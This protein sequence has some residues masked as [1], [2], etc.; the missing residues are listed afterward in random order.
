M[1]LDIW[2]ERSG[3]SFGTFEERSKLELALPVSSSEDITFSII[4]GELPPGL[5]ISSDKIVGTPFEVARVTSFKFCIRA[6]GT[7]GIADRTFTIIIEGADSPTFEVAAGD[8]PIGPN[9]SYY[10]LDSTFVYYQIPAIDF[11]TATGQRL[12]YFISDDDG[13][14]PPGLSLSNDGLL[15][16]FVE[17]AYII[18]S[19]DGDGSYGNGL[20]DN[21]G[22]DFGTIPTD[23][24]DSYAYDSITYD[25]NV[26]TRRVLKV[27]RN[28]E[29]I[30]TLTDSDTVSQR[31]FKIFVVADDYFR[32]DNTALPAS[33]GIFKADGTFLRDPIWK[34]SAYLGLHRANNYLTLILDIYT[35]IDTGL[36]LYNIEADTLWDIDASY[37]VDDKVLYLDKTYICIKETDAVFYG[38]PDGNS[39]NWQVSGIPPGLQFD[40]STG[41]LFGI[42]PY[43]PAITKRY[44]FNVTAKRFSNTTETAFAS[45]TFTV[46]ILGE[47]DS[48]IQW[49]SG[50]YLGSIP[51]NFTSTLNIKATTTVENATL[52]YLQESGTLPPG[53][54]L[55][56]DGEI[57]GKVNQFASETKLGLTRFYEDVPNV[58]EKVFNTIDG[59]STTVDR[60]FEFSVTARDQYGYSSITRTFI[61]DVY[62]PNSKS[63]SNLTVKPFLPISQR[64]TFKTFITDNLIFSANSI[65]RPNDPAFGIQTQLKMIAYAGIETKEIAAYIGAIGLNHKR[66]Q[67]KFGSVKKAV[68]KDTGTNSE[69]YEVVYI[70]MID[71]LEPEGRRLPN[72]KIDKSKDQHKITTDATNDF[73][74]RDLGVLEYDNFYNGRRPD[75]RISIDQSNIQIS[76]PNT[77]AI[78]PSSISNW[79]DRISAVGETERNYLPLWMRSIQPG[80]RS[81]LG[82]VLAVPICF[83]IPGQGQTIMDNIKNSQF[84]FKQLDYTIDRYIIDSVTGDSSDKYLVFKNDRNTIT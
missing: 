45:R 48:T 42:I 83:C 4:S 19:S 58:E 23:G 73:W 70:E 21:V 57:I 28:Y 69:V 51:A 1:A 38:T 74:S 36:V 32:S 2:Q 54:K 64:S 46:D 24:Y 31:K 75:P 65:Y 72:K 30:I 34:T 37:K 78:F 39:I 7:A 33:A 25:Y 81:E 44:I 56:L 3:Y 47:I 10:V 40:I 71:P 50:D 35:T 12:S 27:N 77:R 76:D 59:E 8:L 82:F 62:T 68:A 67:F 55:S 20:Y 66:K 52:V 63:Y 9:N 11:D 16:G 60:S 79:Q 29:F 49:I 17:P 43:Q 22:Y 5:R 6:K 53:L 84:N 80:T 18:K 61:I 14:L 15:S 26:P 41:E 13:E